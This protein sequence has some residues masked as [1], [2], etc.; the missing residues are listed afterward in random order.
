M[1][2]APDA[3]APLAFAALNH[4]AVAARSRRLIN[5]HGTGT[6]HNDSMESLAV[7]ENIRLPHP[8]HLHK[9]LT[10][11]TLARPVRLKPRFYGG[12]VSRRWDPQRQAARANLNGERD[13]ALPEI[14][15]TDTHSACRS[16]AYRLFYRLRLAAAMR[17]W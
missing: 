2:P 1:S 10:G 3:K 9:P 16:S 7:A 17:W 12:M 6:Q 4:A 13:A 5:L 8:V 15:L 14:M 11:H